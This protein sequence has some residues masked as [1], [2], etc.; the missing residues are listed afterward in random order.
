MV[1]TLNP[2]F[3]VTFL[4]LCLYSSEVLAVKVVVVVDLD[5]NLLP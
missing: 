3:Q 4:L 2:F 1:T 5:F